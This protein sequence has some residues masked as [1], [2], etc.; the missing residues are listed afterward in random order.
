[1][2]KSEMRRGKPCWYKA[3]ALTDKAVGLTAINDAFLLESCVFNLLRSHLRDKPYYLNC[4][5]LFLDVTRRTEWGQALDLEAEGLELAQYSMDRYNSIV[6]NK[7]A[8]YSFYL[9][10][11]LAL[12]VA[13]RDSQNELES[14]KTLLLKIGHY[15]QVKPISCWKFQFLPIF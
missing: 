3:V 14:A 2:D 9:P 15:F 13:G 11:A 1:M 5:E 12:H 10:V 7:T 4:L 6:V 8:Y